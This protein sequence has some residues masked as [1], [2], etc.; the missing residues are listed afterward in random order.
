MMNH[1]TV[2]D[3]SRRAVEFRASRIIDRFVVPV[4]AEQC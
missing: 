1:V 3:D 4:F 2:D